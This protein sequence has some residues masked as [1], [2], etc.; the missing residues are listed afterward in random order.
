MFGKGKVGLLFSEVQ[1]GLP[2]NEKACPT[3]MEAGFCD[4]CFT[5]R[6]IGLIIERFIQGSL[7]YVS[8]FA[9]LAFASMKARRGG[10]SSPMT[11]G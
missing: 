1:I 4:L 6:T 5:K 2:Q 3:R 9:Y 10:T 8:I 11:Q 7:N